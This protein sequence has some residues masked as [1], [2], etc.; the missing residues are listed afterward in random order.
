MKN[1]AIIDR[2]TPEASELLTQDVPLVFVADAAL[3]QTTADVTARLKSRGDIHKLPPQ[4]TD[5]LYLDSFDWRLARA[6]NLLEARRLDQGYQLIWSERDSGARRLVITVGELPR[7]AE[8]LDP[9][10]LRDLLAALLEERALMHAA[11]VRT[12]QQMVNVNNKHG[13]TVLR[14]EISEHIAHDGTGG[15][16]EALGTWIRLLPLRGYEKIARRNAVRVAKLATCQP[17][18]EDL[19]TAAARVC[20]IRPLDYSSK[21]NLQLRPEQPAWEVLQNILITTLEGFRQNEEGMCDAIDI[22]FLHDFRVYVRRSRSALTDIQGVISKRALLPWRDELRWLQQLTGE[23]RDLDVYLN[24]LPDYRAELPQEYR[25]GMTA[26]EEFLLRERQQAHLKLTRAI[27]SARYRSFCSQYA[28]FLKTLEQNP[29]A[30]GSHADP[31]GRLSAQLLKKAYQRVLDDGRAIT[32]E[33]QPESL[34]ELRKRCKR[35]RYLLEFFLSLYPSDDISAFVKALKGLQENLGNFQDLEVQAK[36]LSR[37]SGQMAHDKVAPPE[38]FLALGVLIERLHDRTRQARLEFARRFADFD[39]KAT[40]KR[41][42]H[43]CAQ[44]S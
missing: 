30:A 7:A 22:E 41:F 40:R 13:K 33:S 43:M 25:S 1:P 11:H 26:F 32:P 39:T 5:I 21:L 14:V 36:T 24:S 15:R 19:L 31:V 10:P 37:M 34:H 3:A 17:Q 4:Q 42:H 28:A 8:D 20:G 23:S 9:G 27:R 35:L 2:H 16:S 6:G 44:Q 38:T 18:Q 29:S 12:D